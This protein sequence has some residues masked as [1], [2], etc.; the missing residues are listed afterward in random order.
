MTTLIETQ[1]VKDNTSETSDNC[2]Y[3]NVIKIFED[4]TLPIQQYENLIND[5]NIL[6]KELPNINVEKQKEMDKI[7]K[8]VTQFL[9]LYRELNNHNIHFF[10]KSI[11]DIRKNIKI[12]KKKKKESKDKSKYYVNIP[13]DAPPFILKL[14]DK[15]EGEKV[16]QS[17]VLNTI[18]KKI[19][20][21]V[22]S[23]P[24]TYSVFKENGKVDK[25]KF[26]IQDE[27]TEIFNSIKE[28]AKSRGNNINIPE[29]IGYPNLMAYMQYFVYK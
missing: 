12:E 25:T 10:N 28:E 8:Y 17:Q 15:K 4:V 3:Q 13:K 16:S 22:E 7:E 2:D 23:S 14:M 26:K 29:V 27:L 11:I 20:K 24:T 6:I 1:E 9:N 21:C 19:K 18:I 5:I